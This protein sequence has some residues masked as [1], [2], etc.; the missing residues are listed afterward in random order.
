MFHKQNFRKK[1]IFGAKTLLLALFG[2]FSTLFDANT[3]FLAL[4]S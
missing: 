1:G 4:V 2:P 3:P